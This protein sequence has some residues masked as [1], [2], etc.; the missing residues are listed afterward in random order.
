MAQC[1]SCRTF[2]NDQAAFCGQCGNWLGG[3]K[4]KKR[5]RRPVRLPFLAAG[6]LTALGLIVL[7]I[8]YGPQARRDVFSGRVD[9]GGKGGNGEANLPAPRESGENPGAWTAIASGDLESTAELQPIDA[10]RA[11]RLVSKALVVLDLR[12]ED[13]RPLREELGVMIDPS[14]LVLC[15]FR[16]LLGAHHGVCRHSSPDGAREVISGVAM[17]MEDLDLALLRLPRREAEYAAVPLLEEDPALALQSREALYVFS[18]Y[19]AE[20][21]LVEWS[22]YRGTD[23][24]VR[25]LL[26]QEPLVSSDAYLALDAYGFVVGLCKVEVD[27]SFLPDSK[28][29]PSRGYRVVVDPVVSLAGGLASET[30]FSLEE[31]TRRHYEGTFEDFSSRGMLELKRRNW[32]E[33]VN[34]FEKALE[35]VDADEP[36]E[37]ELAMVNAGLREGYVE[38]AARLL[39]ARRTGEAAAFAEA[40]LR[41]SAGDAAL[42]RVLGECRFLQEDWQAAI[43]ALLQARVVEPGG[44][45]DSLL[46]RSYLPL[47]AAAGAAGDA[48]AQ[49]AHLLR[50]I[51]AL[52][53][54]GSL[55]IELGKLY[56]SFQVYDDAIRVLERCRE[57]APALRGAAEN[58]L[59]RIDDALKRRESVIIPIASDSKS[60]RT[61]AQVD[62]I[63]RFTFLIDTGASYTVI[64]SDLAEALR[65]DTTSLRL[66]RRNVL[67]AGG[68]VNAPLITLQSLNLGGYS[69]RN[70]EAIVLPSST[71][72][73]Y[74]LIGLNFLNHF[75]YTV[76]AARNEF[77]LQRP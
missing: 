41:R 38:E 20:E 72:P 55:L 62:G 40:G 39:E 50:G 48:R 28:P 12:T 33:A 10:S 4:P 46:E 23:R 3:P 1:P 69:V 25:V 15:R 26:A 67:T 31:L 57:V 42:L 19:K 30:V 14:G 16:P 21:A 68:V 74:G 17:V 2:N 56:M 77:R 9:L 45:L 7:G 65:Y 11:T 73:E 18:S 47:A 24:I 76:D 60:I 54:A 6:I 51:E 52:P 29:R 43:D 8:T 35:R 5:R 49:E 36:E 44:D 70:L 59:A 64:P 63:T 27:G 58:L 75:K 22:Y 53:S 66:P 13:D 71:L 32:R 34:L 61:E 37:E